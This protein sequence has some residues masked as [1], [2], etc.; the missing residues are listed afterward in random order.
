[1][2][3]TLVMTSKKGSDFFVLPSRTYVNAR[4]ALA[5]WIQWALHPVRKEKALF[6]SQLLFFKEEIEEILHGNGLRVFIFIM[7]AD[8]IDKND[9]KR[10]QRRVVK[11]ENSTWSWR[12]KERSVWIFKDLFFQIKSGPPKKR[13]VGFPAEKP[14][15][16]V[17]CHET[18]HPYNNFVITLSKFSKNSVRYTQTPQYIVHTLAVKNNRYYITAVSQVIEHRCLRRNSQLWFRWFKEL[19]KIPSFKEI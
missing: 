7:Q 2:P 8:N 15:K 19:R 1:M 6:F 13:N 10:K 9:K 14:R 4:G 12:K 11:K 16:W 5:I 17:F 18:G 3:T